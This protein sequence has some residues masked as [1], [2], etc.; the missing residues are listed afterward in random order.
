MEEIDEHKQKG[1]SLF[2]CD[3]TCD[4]ARL[5]VGGFDRNLY[6]YDEVDNKHELIKEMC[7]KDLTI[8]GH[9]NRINCIKGHPK[10]PHW[11][12]SSGWDNTLKIYD[13]EKGYPIA[14]IGGSEC[15]GD[16]IDVYGDMILTGSCRNH[17]EITLISSSKK[18]VAF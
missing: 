3:F 15:S 8:T 7:S 10:N 9:H 16:S 12:L 14:S 5:V 1:N 17:Q 6:V 11:V 2:A 18:K 4:G 13:V